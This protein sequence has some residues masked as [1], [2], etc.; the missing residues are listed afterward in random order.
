[1]DIKKLIENS[2]ESIVK[3]V[4]VFIS[5]KDFQENLKKEISK[6]LSDEAIVEEYADNTNRIDIVLKSDNSIY[7]IELKYSF[8]ENGQY[9]YGTNTEKIPYLFVADIAKLEDFIA[10]TNNAD[11]GYC[12]LLTNDKDIVSDNWKS[13]ESVDKEFN[14]SQKREKSLG[15]TLTSQSADPQK[16]PITL[17]GNYF[18]QDNW[19]QSDKFNYLIIEISK[20]DIA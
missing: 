15:K 12:I 1:M 18:P 5:E 4:K 10:K 9:K 16:P 13:D 7:P 19:K 6:T 11:K 14:I 8:Y 2:I 20:G 17:K 3:N